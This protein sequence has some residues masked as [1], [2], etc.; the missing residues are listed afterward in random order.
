MKYEK[1]TYQMA[2]AQ[3]HILLYVGNR[4]NKIPIK[5]VQSKLCQIMPVVSSNNMT[6]YELKRST[7]LK[8]LHDLLIILPMYGEVVCD[9]FFKRV[10]YFHYLV[11]VVQIAW[12]ESDFIFL[13]LD[14]DVI[15]VRY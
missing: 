9:H 8:L 1:P 6:D 5:A 12:R 7:Q 14:N 10:A 11:A 13:L 2:L 15:H 4:K 3:K